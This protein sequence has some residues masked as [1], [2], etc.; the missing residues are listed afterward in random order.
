M[1]EFEARERRES[2]DYAGAKVELVEPATVLAAARVNA[3]ELIHKATWPAPVQRVD[4][5]V[6]SADADGEP[7]H[8]FTSAISTAA[9]PLSRESV[10][11]LVLGADPIG[12]LLAKRIDEGDPLATKIV[13]GVGTAAL[14]AYKKL[15]L[16]RVPKPA[17]Q[18]EPSTLADATV[19]LQASVTY[20]ESGTIV[21]L[22]AEVP[23]DAVSPAHLQAFAGL[24][25]QAVLELAGPESLTGR[26]YVLSRE[27]VP[28]PKMPQTTQNVT[29]DQVGG[30]AD[31]VAE[32]R[33]IAVSFRHPE[34]MARWGARRPQG[35]LMYGP[36]GTGKTMLSRALANEIGADFRE[37][38]TPEI[39]DKWLGG[40]ERN[41]K[42]I[43]REARRYRVPTLILFD[44]FD[45]IISY[46]GSGGDAASQAI[47]AVAGIFKQEMNDLIEANPNV[48]VVATTNFPHRVDDSLI[49]SGRFDVKVSVPKPDEASRAEIFRK[50]IRGLIATHEAPGF[51]MFADDL[52]LAELARTS[53]GMTGADIKEVL[54]R[55]QLSKAMQDARTGGV[56]D[57]ISQA[58]LAAGIRE[59]ALPRPGGA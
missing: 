34:A 38:R 35:I 37:I 9:D 50:M 2:F 56:V 28:Q 20:D 32:L 23:R 51:K 36:P 22:R 33:Q 13:D 58:D 16:D 4:L 41:I 54:R 53:H 57:P 21:R 19:G 27:S 12:I 47:N 55:V 14:A 45:S 46:A 3:V 44:E 26:R 40:S 7:M 52:D 18:R 43:F 59:M 29:L 39:L 6:S 5:T 24:T 42:Q 25:L 15:G 10:R 8:V 31:I 1:G 49:R 48:I 17:T 11:R 30:L